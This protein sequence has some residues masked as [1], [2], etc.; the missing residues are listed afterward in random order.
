MSYFGLSKRDVTATIVLPLL[1]MTLP[2]C[3]CWIYG[4]ITDTHSFYFSFRFMSL[5]FIG[6]TGCL[7]RIKIEMVESGKL[8]NKNIEKRIDI[9][10]TLMIW[11]AFALM[12]FFCIPAIIAIIVLAVFKDKSIYIEKFIIG[13]TYFLANLALFV[14]GI[15]IEFKGEFPKEQHAVCLNHESWI[16]YVIWPV[17]GGLKLSKVVAGK[18][19]VK[20]PGIG[21]FIAARSILIDR[22]DESSA[23]KT[24]KLIKKIMLAGYNLIWNPGAG[25]DRLSN[26]GKMK[27]FL[28]GTFGVFDE[29][30]L[31]VPTLVLET[32]KYKPA[33]KGEIPWKTL[34]FFGKISAFF[35]FQWWSSPRLI[36][37]VVMEETCRKV[38]EVKLVEVVV[39][40]VTVIEEEKVLE[41]RDVCATRIYTLMDTRKQIELSLL[42]EQRMAA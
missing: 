9:F 34:T 3:L 31:I 11:P 27:K 26:K 42:E 35:S 41:N 25:R 15:R 23:K 37:V 29:T 10:L 28:S 14:L 36:H 24:L 19:L 6:I 16:D 21:Q 20:F 40:E 18:N 4:Q 22:K 2:Y 30:I 1:I 12:L 8:K 17:L 33:M 5:A 13:V 39:D 38:E 32:M 7:A